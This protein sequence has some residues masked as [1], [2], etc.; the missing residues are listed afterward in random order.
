MSRTTL[1]LDEGL[2]WG[3]VGGVLLGVA[4]VVLAYIT[5]GIWITFKYLL[6]HP[7]ITLLLLILI[8]VGVI[9]AIIRI[10]RRNRLREE[11]ESVTQTHNTPLY[12]LAKQTEVGDKIRWK[13]EKTDVKKPR[14]RT[15]TSVHYGSESIT[16]EADGPQG[17]QYGFRVN[18][19][20]ESEAW[21]LDTDSGRRSQ[22]PIDK[23]EL[24]EKEIFTEPWDHWMRTQ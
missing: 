12:Q 6:N 15:I 4:V 13:G 1:T 19:E 7:L 3:I 16:V 22:G 10:G 17:G 9:E 2:G 5:W 8:I 20:G 18:E 11:V 14:P 24:V 21:F 23:A